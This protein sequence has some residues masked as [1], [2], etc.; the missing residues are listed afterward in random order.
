M[1]VPLTSIN[2]SYPFSFAMEKL[3]ELIAI[4][5]DYIEYQGISEEEAPLPEER[6][7]RSRTEPWVSDVAYATTT[8]GSF[9]Q[10]PE[11][12]RTRSKWKRG[13]ISDEEYE[14]KIKSF[15]ADCV[16]RQEETGLDVLVH[17]E[18]E[19]PDMVQYF[20]ENFEGFTPI[21]GEVQ[22]YGTRFV[23]PP[24]VTGTISRPK[25]FTVPWS[26]YAQSLTDKPIKGMLTGP[27]TLS[28]WSFP[29][30]DISRE[31]QFYEFA[32]ALRAEVN[33]LNAAGIMHV[34]VD[35]PAIREGLPLDR[36]K[37][38]H[39]LFHAVNSFRQVFADMPDDAVAHTHMCFSEFG[40]IWS[41]IRDMGADV[42]LVEDSK[43]QSKLVD[44]IGEQGFSASIGLGVFDVHSPR[45]PSVE[46]MAQVP[47]RY[48]ENLD[49]NRIWVNPDCGL[50]TRGEEAW[51]QLENMVEAVQKL[52]TDS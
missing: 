51:E 23:R 3:G 25:A 14:E 46:E 40:D 31:A 6:I 33:D 27:V 28:R 4:K 9:P 32:E 16:R 8:T 10:L 47:I 41:S 48:S 7:E 19:R 2:E 43:A 42:Y 44:I 1:H 21:K 12:R 5:G 24:V 30:E 35:E 15:I 13:E 38:D 50:K 11:V 49:A 52:R 20:A 17:G 22:S 26:S 18:F 34:Q 36:E 39:Y 29:R 37:W 45:I